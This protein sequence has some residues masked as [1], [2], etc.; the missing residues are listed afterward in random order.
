MHLL[1]LSLCACVCVSLCACVQRIQD[2]KLLSLR[3]WLLVLTIM[4]FYNGIFPFI[5]DA[6]SAYRSISHKI[7]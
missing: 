7:L 5:A 2:V 1:E 3:Y 4:F 6:R